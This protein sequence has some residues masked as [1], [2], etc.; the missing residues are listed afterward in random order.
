MVTNTEKD[1]GQ[2]FWQARHEWIRCLIDQGDY[3]G[4]DTAWRYIERTTNDFDQGKF[5]YKDKFKQLRTELD[6][7]VFRKEV[8]QDIG[9]K[10]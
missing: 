10:K 1:T 6:K 2:L 5:G 4:A 7:K 3:E 9:T 8:K